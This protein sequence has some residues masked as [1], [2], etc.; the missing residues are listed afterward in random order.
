M[1]H[2]VTSLGQ[3]VKTILT[4]QE[5]IAEGG[6][7]KTFRYD[8]D[9][10][11]IKYKWELISTHTGRRTCAT[12]MYL[13]KKY[14]IREMM[15]IKGHKRVE[16]FMKYIKLSLDEEAYQLALSNDGEMF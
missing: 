10:N 5:R 4:K 13:S 9:E 3:D 15:L 2:T 12:N 14:D 7:T 8:E 1:S 16:T 6:K 11:A